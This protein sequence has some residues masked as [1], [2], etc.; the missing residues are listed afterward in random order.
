MLN[1]AVNTAV[2]FKLTIASTISVSIITRRD[3][4]EISVKYL[5]LK[6]VKLFYKHVKGLIA[7][8]M[9]YYI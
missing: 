8:K 6:T 2:D 4:P 1:T 7:V 5:G 9:H 3:I